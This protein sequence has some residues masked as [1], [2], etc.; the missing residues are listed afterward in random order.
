M[1]LVKTLAAITLLSA[2]FAACNNHEENPKSQENLV[3]SIV[4]GHD[5]VQEEED[6]ISYNLPSALQIA[7]VFRK[8]GAVYNS[9]LPND[10]QN[11]GKYNMSSYKSALNF[12]IYSTDLAYC[13][14]NKKNQESKAYLK[15]CKETGTALGLSQA[16][17]SDNFASRFEKNI[18]H[19]DSL[20]KIVSA[21]QLKTDVMLEQ[22]KQKHITVLAFAGAWT[23]SLYI[24]NQSYIDSKSKQKSVLASLLEQLSLSSTIL[25]ALKAHEKNDANIPALI[26]Q[27]EQIKNAYES[28]PVV[29][30][31]L[32]KDDELDMSTLVLPNEQLNRV[33]EAIQSLRKSIVE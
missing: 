24:A 18:S 13:I 5:S 8:S 30:T 31:A 23:E 33:S 1:K 14:F 21:I 22:N 15:A 12:G 32:E 2:V 19:E 3:D 9:T 10:V 7:Y 17:E 29:K 11:T 16:F 6:E 25:K 26:L 4:A 20:V 27:I 28:I